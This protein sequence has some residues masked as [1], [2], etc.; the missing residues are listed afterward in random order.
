MIFKEIKPGMV[1]HC[2]TQE[3]AKILVGHLNGDKDYVDYW[4]KY[5]QDTHYEIS[6]RLKPTTFG[7]RNL[8]RNSMHQYQIVEFTDLIITDSEKPVSQIIEEVRETVCDHL[9]KYSDT[10]DEDGVCDY[11]RAHDGNCP[12][13]RLQ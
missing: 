2:K 11:M 7:T 13:D 4:T 12:L 3:E 8:Y 10:A 5:G 9:C 1:I 6:S